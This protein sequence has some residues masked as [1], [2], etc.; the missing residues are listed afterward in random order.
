[1]RETE[2]DARRL[3]ARAA[4]IEKRAER[5]CAESREHQSLNAF[6]LE[7]RAT[8]GELLTEAS[9]LSRRMKTELAV[10]PATRH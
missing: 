8:A 5:A 9:E 6:A 3:I 1:M 7:L 4:Y 2:Q 10:V